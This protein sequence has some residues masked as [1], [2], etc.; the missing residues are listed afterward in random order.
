MS[1]I[2]HNKVNNISRRRFI[3]Q[4]ATFG[5]GAA[6]ASL[7]AGFPFAHITYA[8]KSPIKTGERNKVIKSNDEWKRLLTPE[9]FSVTRMKGTERP[10][11]GEYLYNKEEGIYQC[12]CCNTELFSSETKYDSHTG[13]P[14][15]W[16]PIASE[17]I[18]KKDDYSFFMRRVEVLCSVCDAHLGHI[19]NDGPPPTHLRYCINSVA[20]KFI[21]QVS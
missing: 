3:A 9:Q 21:K 6:A 16:T 2:G 5:M 13:W 14:S 8:A 19:F 7:L 18:L 20:L 1:K 4:T 10:Y 12:V 11:S 15:F 17:N